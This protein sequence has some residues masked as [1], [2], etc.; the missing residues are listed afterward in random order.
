MKY[1]QTVNRRNINVGVFVLTDPP[2]GQMPPPE[3]SVTVTGTAQAV[4]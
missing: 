1:G 2:P 3:R 4:E